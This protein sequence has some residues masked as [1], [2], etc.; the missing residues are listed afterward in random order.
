MK[1]LTDFIGWK[2]KVEDI[3]L[4]KLDH[5]FITDF[6]FYLHSECGISGVSGA[7]Y[8]KNLKKIVN[9]YLAHG[10]LPRIL[11]AITNQNKAR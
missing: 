8:I 6:D 7:R 1:H 10:L 4:Y 9:S 2:F 5:A 3:E 11:L